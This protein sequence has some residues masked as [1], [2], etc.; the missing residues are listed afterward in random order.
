MPA[1]RTGPKGILAESHALRDKAADLEEKAYRA[2]L[3]ACD[4]FEAPAADVLGVKRS[5]FKKA[6]STRF[7]KLGDEAA[8]KREDAGYKG[9]NPHRFK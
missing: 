6:L 3:E 1:A 9:G 4:W 8:R 5:A 7:K 2:A